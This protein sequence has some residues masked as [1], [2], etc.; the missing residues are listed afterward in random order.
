MPL[1]LEIN[2]VYTFQT[3]AP[4]ILGAVIRNARLVF[5]CNYETAMSFEN[6]EAKYR[7][8]YPVLPQGVPYSPAKEI[9]Y[10]FRTESGE[11]IF[12]ADPWIVGSS[13][14]TVTSVGFTVHVVNATLQSKQD[15]RRA[16]THLGLDFTIVD[17]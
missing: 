17:Q 10:R 16:M 1:N 8:I 13:L 15:V 12:V 14:I 9:F 6:V 2:E 7:A 3:H 11:Q 4:A 5:K